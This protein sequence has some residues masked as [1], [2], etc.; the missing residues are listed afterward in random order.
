MALLIG[1]VVVCSK[2]AIGCPLVLCRHVLEVNLIVFNLLEFD[3][4][5]GMYW[6]FQHYSCINCFRQTVSFL[7]PKGEVVEF[8]RAKFS[9]DLE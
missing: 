1:K 3:I 4:I 5:L 6:L 8:S 2:V 9:R 7:S